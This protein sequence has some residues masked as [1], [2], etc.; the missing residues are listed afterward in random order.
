LDEE[1]DD[2]PR[3]LFTLSLHCRRFCPNLGGSILGVLQALN[4]HPIESILTTLLNEITAVMDNFILVLDDYHMLDSKAVD[5]ALTFFFEHLPPQ[6]HMVITTREDPNLP[7]P[8]L[9]VRN[10]LTEMR[11]ADLRFTPVRSRRISQS[12]D[13]P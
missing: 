3:F 11:A 13:E 6:M 9:R 7:I 1:D 12:G 5:D 8:R 10:Q 2:D 4:H